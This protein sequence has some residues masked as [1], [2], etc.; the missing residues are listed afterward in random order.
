MT[1]PQPTLDLFGQTARPL[2]RPDLAAVATALVGLASVIL[3]LVLLA[4]RFEWLLPSIDPWKQMR[5]EMLIALIS[6]LI[7]AAAVLVFWF[8]DPGRGNF[9]PLPHRLMTLA[10]LLTL[11]L[12]VVAYSL[13]LAQEDPRSSRYGFFH[14]Y[15]TIY[16]PL[17]LLALC[18]AVVAWTFALV[19][20]NLL[21]RYLQS[22]RLMVASSVVFG[23][24][25]AALMAYGGALF[26][27]WSNA[28]SGLS[29]GPPG[30]PLLFDLLIVLRIVAIAG[31]AAYMFSAT[32]HLLRKHR[33]QHS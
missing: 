7:Q 20:A 14:F 21:A 18:L 6:S 24:Q 3:A 1:Q 31:L 19:Y 13:F 10:A 30:A 25:L 29:F 9:S 22:R 32:A 11:L 12:A 23:L 5:G 4:P 27:H 26:V 28:F 33:A 2:R 15:D 16:I 17:I 8:A